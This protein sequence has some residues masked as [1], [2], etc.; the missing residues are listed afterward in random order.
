MGTLTGGADQL[1]SGADQ[2]SQGADQLASG[3]KKFN[4]QGIKKLVSSLDDNQLTDMSSRLKAAA[5]AS[6]RPVFMGG[7]LSG[8]DGESKIIYKTGGINDK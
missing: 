4:D 2:L 5:E 6:G 7:K 3:M 1:G 8:M